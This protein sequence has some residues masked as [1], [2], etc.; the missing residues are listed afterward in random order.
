MNTADKTTNRL[1]TDEPGNLKSE[2]MKKYRETFVDRLT[3]GDLQELQFYRENLFDNN[4]RW[5]TEYKLKFDTKMRQYFP[6]E[7]LRREIASIEVLV[8]LLVP[9]DLVNP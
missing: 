7:V 6:E 2:L 3:V 8:S 9:A 1:T 4:R 5:N